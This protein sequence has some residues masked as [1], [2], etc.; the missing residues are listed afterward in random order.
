MHSLGLVSV[1]CLPV[2]IMVTLFAIVGTSMEELMKSIQKHAQ[3][4][5]AD[6][7]LPALPPSPLDEFQATQEGQKLLG[8]LAQNPDYE[9]R[10]SDILLTV[11]DR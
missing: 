2:T 6:E 9:E 5:P 7:A 10:L 8:R 1:P 4:E 3:D 11:C